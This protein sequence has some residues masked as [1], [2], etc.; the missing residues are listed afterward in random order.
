MPSLRANGMDLE[1]ETIGNAEDPPLLLVMGL[2]AQMIVWDDEFCRMLADRGFHVIRYDNRD[3]GLS[4][5]IE[6]AEIDF[7]QALGPALSG[8]EVDAPYLLSDMAADAAALLDALDI[9]A[10]HVVGASMGGM[11]A[12]ALAIEHPEK[13][14]TLTSIMSTTG[15]R[16]VGQPTPEAMQVLLAPAAQD[17]ESAIEQSVKASRVIS[18][19][20]HFDEA[21]ARERAGA[22][23][24]RCF[25]P[26]GIG[27]QLLA[28]LASGDRTGALRKLDVPALVVHGAVD[29]LV[30]I[31]GGRATADAIPGAELL[32]IDGMGHDLPPMSWPRVV[33]AICELAGRVPAHG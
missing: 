24:D 32:V 4:T 11:I 17:R 18:S 13:V 14:L 31:S 20:E 26:A 9:P 5:K 28:I 27:R 2:G 7:A 22:G 29:P 21:K 12:Q 33:D 10:A 19:P 15:D 1:Y 6:S 16:E 3:C 30:T 25:Y 23:Y 8:G